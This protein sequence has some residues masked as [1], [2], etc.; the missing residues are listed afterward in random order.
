MRQ[1]MQHSPQE[2]L[3][4]YGQLSQHKQDELFLHLRTM[5][6]EEQELAAKTSDINKE[7]EEFIG[8]GAGEMKEVLSIEKMNE[9]IAAGWAGECK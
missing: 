6:E 1:V 5:L 8:C 2:F 9:I 3:V 4:L 7:L